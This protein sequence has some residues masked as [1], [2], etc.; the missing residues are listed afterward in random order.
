MVS[1]LSAQNKAIQSFLSY[2]MYA[3]PGETPFI[4]NAMAFDC[5]SVYYRQFEPGKFKASV[6]IQT[7]FKQGDKVC[8]YSKIALDSPVVTD[9]S[10]IGGSFI[11]QQRFEIGT[12]SG[13]QL[14]IGTPIGV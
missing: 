14:P 12:D 7:I 4:E 1:S 2:T 9:T 11:D 13:D 6:E 8:N 10:K 5:S 3:V